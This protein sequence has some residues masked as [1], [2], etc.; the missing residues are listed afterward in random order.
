MFGA[1]IFINGSTEANSSNYICAMF[2]GDK[3]Q[4]LY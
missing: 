2:L 3:H 1:I 4:L